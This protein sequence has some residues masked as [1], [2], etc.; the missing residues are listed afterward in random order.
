MA[1]ITKSDEERKKTLSA[2]EYRV[3]RESGTERALRG[4]TGAITNRE[5]TC[6]RNV[7]MGYLPPT[8][9]FIPISVGHVLMRQ[10]TRT[11]ER[12]KTAAFS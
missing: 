2:E 5:D 1:K 7:G 11:C 3:L 4:R 6:A 8:R 9:N 10:C 12:E